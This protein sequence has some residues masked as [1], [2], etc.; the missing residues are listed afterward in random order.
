MTALKKKKNR[1]LSLEVS[2]VQEF[3]VFRDPVEAYLFQFM[4][5]K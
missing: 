5:Q 2:R 4:K 3:L 1:N